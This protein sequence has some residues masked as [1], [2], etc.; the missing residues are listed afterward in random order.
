[1]AGWD[2]IEYNLFKKKKL[3]PYRIRDISNDKNIINGTGITFLY[4]AAFDIE[5]RYMR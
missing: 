2:E 1:M 5:V 3:T 4:F